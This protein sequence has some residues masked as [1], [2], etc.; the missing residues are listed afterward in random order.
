[1]VS[2]RRSA[3]RGLIVAL[4]VF[5]LTGA[6]AFAKTLIV[7]VWTLEGQEAEREIAAF[8]AF[9]REAR[10]DI[11]IVAGLRDRPQFIALL[12][13][14]GFAGFEARV[15]PRVEPSSPARAPGRGLLGIA[16]RFDIGP[17]ARDADGPVPAPP[18]VLPEDQWA[19]LTDAASYW[20][21]LPGQRLSVVAVDFASSLGPPGRGDEP[22]SWRREN[23]AAALAARIAA[24]R[25][26]RPGWSYLVAGQF[27]VAPRDPLKV[28]PDLL[29]RCWQEACAA[30]DQTHALLAEGLVEN[31]RLT[32]PLADFDSPEHDTIVETALE[33]VYLFGPRFDG[34]EEA[35]GR[36]FGPYG[37]ER[38]ILAVALRH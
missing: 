22:V 37:P 15:E 5:L 1:M 17:E 31:L 13:A 27:G 38:R 36:L 21:D 9:G 14:G 19:P 24:Q 18:A 32:N 35:S 16:S 11:L 25:A 6:T 26:A 23:A 7:A 12:M 34:L 20:L 33:T 8:R 2:G 29:R 30:Y 4:V 10:P 28:G 3:T